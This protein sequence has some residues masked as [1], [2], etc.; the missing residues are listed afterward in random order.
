MSEF[1]AN[2][3][4]RGYWFHKI[5]PELTEALFTGSHNTIYTETP[6]DPE[7][8]DLGVGIERTI[9]LSQFEHPTGTS[10]DVDRWNIAAIAF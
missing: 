7:G 9:A 1:S 3:N 8:C 6:V 2:K 10:G 4:I 5:N